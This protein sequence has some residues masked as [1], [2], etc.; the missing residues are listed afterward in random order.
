MQRYCNKTT[1]LKGHK[2][3][4]V[5]LVLILSFCVKSI[6]PLKRCSSGIKEDFPD[7]LPMNPVKPKYDK[8]KNKL[9]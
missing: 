4:S 1:N 5:L 7:K 8:G 3:L 6:S 2:Q 9:V